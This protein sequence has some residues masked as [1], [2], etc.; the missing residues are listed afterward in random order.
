MPTSDIQ[1]GSVFDFPPSISLLPCREQW[2]IV[3]QSAEQVTFFGKRGKGCTFFA[4]LP[5]QEFISRRVLSD[6]E[7]LEAC[8]TCRVW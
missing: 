1:T 8:T 7:G 4:S 6:S 3:A 5:H 2:D